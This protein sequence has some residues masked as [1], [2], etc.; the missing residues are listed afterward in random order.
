[1]KL[2]LLNKN[3]C[4]IPICYAYELGLFEKYNFAFTPHFH[5]G[6]WTD[7][8]M[9]A[10]GEIPCIRGDY[11]RYLIFKDLENCDPVITHTFS[12][13]FQI[14]SKH[15]IKDIK[16]LDGGSC[17]LS[18]TTSVEFYL[19][20]FC[21]DNNITI[22]KINER[23]IEERYTRFINGE[24]DLVMIPEPYA[25]KLLARG[26]HLLHDIRDTDINIKVYM[27]DREFLNNNPEIPQKFMD[28][29]N[30]ATLL[31][32]DLDE[33]NQYEYLLKYDMVDNKDEFFK[34]SYEL[35]LPFTEKSLEAAKEWFGR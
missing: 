1:M 25:S 30:E 21:K 4:I 13:D 20:Q 18:L 3:E 22:N 17:L 6:I 11:S 26:Y 35:N 9:F 12:R 15:K 14:L 10:S 31:F 2:P 28:I 23:V 7:H 8:D 5:D 19:D 32:N 27:W 24:S 16:T 34:K 29:I 33:D